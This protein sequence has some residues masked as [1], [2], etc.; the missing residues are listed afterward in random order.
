MARTGI[1][2]DPI[3]IEHKTGSYHPESP[4][5]LEVI[6][7]MLEGGEM[8]EIFT[9]LSPR[10]ATREEIELIHDPSYFD[11]VAATAGKSH[12][13]LDPDTQTSE[14]SFEAA[15][16][17]AG[18][19]LLGIDKVMAGELDNVFALVRPPGH[20]AEHNRGMGFCLFNN[21]AIGALYAINN[22]DLDRILI[23]DW[24]LH[25]GNGTQHSFYADKRIVYFSTH[26]YPYYPGTGSFEEVGRG[27]GEGFTVNVPLNVGNGDGE[28]YRIFRQ[29]LEP[30]ADDYKPQLVLVS[31]GFDIYYKDPLGGMQVTPQGFAALTKVL[32]DIAERHSDKKLLITL[33]GGYHLGGLRDGV[34]DVIKQL[35]G[36]DATDPD[37][38][39]K[40]VDSIGE[41]AKRPIEKTISVQKKYWDCF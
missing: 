19:L 40:D 8:K 33:E 5:R 32:M 18:G 38:V 28:Y 1:V 39:S 13:S 15:L 16:D 34:G 24:D 20:H 10:K 26:Q 37:L 7:E 41:G 9:P 36:M 29:V 4:E 6:Y 27:D 35:S 12:S 2:K 14:K 22:Y 11:K 3:Y 31:A 17:A 21:V 25:H 30:I 23:V